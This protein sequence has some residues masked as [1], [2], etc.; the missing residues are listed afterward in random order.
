M[1]SLFKDE[2]RRILKDILAS[3]R[4]DLEGRFRLITE[5]YTPLM[6]FL[7][8]AGAPFPTGLQTASDFVLHHDIRAQ[9]EAD[10]ID[11]ERLR[12][13]FREANGR[14]PDIFDAEISYGAVHR[15]EQMILKLAA[16][17][18]EIERIRTLEAVASLVVPIPMGL[19]LWKVQN[20]YWEMLQTVLPRIPGPL[21]QRRRIRETMDEG[22]P[23]ARQSAEFRS[24]ASP[25]SS[26]E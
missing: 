1:K 26:P 22:I 18:D 15:L 3:T 24:G 20:T 10:E 19:N 8:S 5:R 23:G 16:H 21:Q 9:F 12:S 7:K 14:V 13:L 6:K 2:Q 11:L 25:S 4:E 17:P